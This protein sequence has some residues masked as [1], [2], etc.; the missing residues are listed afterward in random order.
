MSNAGL[1]LDDNIRYLHQGI[2][3]IKSISDPVY[4]RAFPP[5]YKSGVGPHFR[6]CL[7]HYSSLIGGLEGG[8]I[9]YDSRERDTRIEQDR[10]FTVALI[11]TLILALKSIQEDQLDQP[12]QSKTD[13]GSDDANPWCSS[14]VRRELQFLVSHTV[15]HYA[16]IAMILRHQ[17]VEP[18]A[19]FGVAPSTL[20]HEEK[21]ASCAR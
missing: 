19:T 5:L 18:P 13:C 6:H 11:Q 9:D 3:L 17:G 10:A 1:I 4:T 21:Q 8:R 15:H 2:E 7:D 14:S 12:V 20:R 16:L